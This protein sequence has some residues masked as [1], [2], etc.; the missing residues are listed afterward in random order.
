[1]K[2]EK[3]KGGPFWAVFDHQGELVCVCV[4]KRGALEVVRRLMAACR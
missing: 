4:Y 2:I 1:M 3:W